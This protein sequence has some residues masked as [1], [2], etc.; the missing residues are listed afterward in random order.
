MMDESGRS[1][2]ARETRPL[3]SA[4]PGAS[5]DREA[6]EA[7]SPERA[8]ALASSILQRHASAVSAEVRGADDSLVGVVTRRG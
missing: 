8:L 4:P 1:G 6:L 3:R 2:R 5:G 7:V